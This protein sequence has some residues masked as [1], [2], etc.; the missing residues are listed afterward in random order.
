MDETENSILC[1]I[2]GWEELVLPLITP[3]SPVILSFKNA[4]LSNYCGFSLNI[5]EDSQIIMDQIDSDPRV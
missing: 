3:Q 4:K 1:C 5:N 2:W